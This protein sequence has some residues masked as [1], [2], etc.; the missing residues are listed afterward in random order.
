MDIV[1]ISDAV[2]VLEYLHRRELLCTSCGDRL[3]VYENAF[4]RCCAECK[5]PHGEFN[6][7]KVPSVIEKCIVSALQ[8]WL[9]KN[10]P[11]AQPGDG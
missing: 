4:K 7:A 3:A 10:T 1:T 6:R 11:D 5:P 8:R 9:A 2:Q